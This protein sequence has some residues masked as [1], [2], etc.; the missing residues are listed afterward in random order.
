MTS[1]SI[2]SGPLARATR[3]RRSPG[4]AANGMDTEPAHRLGGELRITVPAEKHVH[5][6][7]PAEPGDEQGEKEYPLVPEG[8][9]HRLAVLPATKRIAVVDQPYTKRRVQQPER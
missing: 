2:M 4:R 6:S 3:P 7:R 1:G 9:E 5:R 8:G